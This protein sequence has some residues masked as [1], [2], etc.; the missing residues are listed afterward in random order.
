VYFKLLRIVANRP[1]H[2]CIKSRIQLVEATLVD[3]LPYQKSLA[4]NLAT[5]WASICNA[6]LQEWL[7]R[8]IKALKNLLRVVLHNDHK[9]SRCLRVHEL[10]AALTELKL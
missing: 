5:V 10:A 2:G 8:A 1:L 6:A 4:S 3:L 7:E 9:H